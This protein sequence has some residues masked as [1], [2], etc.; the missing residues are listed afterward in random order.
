MSKNSEWVKQFSYGDREAESIVGLGLDQAAT[1]I[2]ITD[3]IRE[4]A[5]WY[6]R[7]NADTPIFNNPSWSDV[8]KRQILA[9]FLITK[10]GER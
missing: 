10:Y 1:E 9:K 7:D 3:E 2:A 8:Q 6:W 4:V 5:Y